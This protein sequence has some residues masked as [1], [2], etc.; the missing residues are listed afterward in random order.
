MATYKETKNLKMYHYKKTEISALYQCIAHGTRTVY[1]HWNR[2]ESFP[3]LICNISPL[4][5]KLIS[6]EF[7]EKD[8]LVSENTKPLPPVVP[9]HQLQQGNPNNM[10]SNHTR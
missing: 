3:I 7:E 6:A 9:T 8:T 2:H 4:S 10:H 1:F 5:Q